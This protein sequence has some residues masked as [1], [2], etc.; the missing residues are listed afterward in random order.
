MVA[1]W[2]LLPAR[3]TQLRSLSHSCCV[4]GSLAPHRPKLLFPLFLVHSL[5]QET[6]HKQVQQSNK[7]NWNPHTESQQ[8]HLKSNCTPSSTQLS[9]GPE[10]KQVKQT[11]I[12]NGELGSPTCLCRRAGQHRGKGDTA[13]GGQH[14]VLMFLNPSLI[15]F[16]QPCQYSPTQALF[17]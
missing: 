6:V 13:E 17:C 7:S 16:T 11:G 8:P 3:G 5:G 10:D 9:H 4:P 2:L 1:R 12:T 15:S 14:W